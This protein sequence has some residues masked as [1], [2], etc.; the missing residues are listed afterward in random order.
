MLGEVLLIDLGS[1]EIA[2]VSGPDLR[3][4]VI[5]VQ[6]LR[7]IKALLDLFHGGALVRAFGNLLGDKQFE[8]REGVR[9]PV[10]FMNLIFFWKFYPCVLPK[11]VSSVGS[12]NTHVSERGALELRVFEQ[13]AVERGA[14]ELRVV[15]RGAL[16]LRAVER[17]AL[18]SRA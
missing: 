7:G 18:W 16:Q 15:E 17:G 1:G 13:R 10:A 3:H 2:F 14:L 4:L 5:A 8:C 11:R 6:G 12:P 9:R